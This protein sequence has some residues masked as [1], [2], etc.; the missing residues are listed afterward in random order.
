MATRVA[1]SVT[2]AV[3]PLAAMKTLRD[4]FGLPLLA[5]KQAVREHSPVPLTMPWASHPSA[6]RELALSEV[7]SHLNELLTV[8][9]RLVAAGATTQVLIG[10]ERLDRDG[11]LSA[12]A[13]VN[14]DSLARRYRGYPESDLLAIATG[15]AIVPGQPPATERELACEE[16]KTRLRD[17]DAA[18]L[19]WTADSARAPQLRR[20]LARLEMARRGVDAASL[21]I[22]A[23][24][25]QH[26]RGK[27]A[28]DTRHE[29]S[30]CYLTEEHDWKVSMD[31]RGYGHGCSKCGYFE[32]D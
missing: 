24:P 28:S 5:A 11:L 21:R 12:V 9:D 4:L 10:D 26:P 14:A 19:L 30:C 2:A 13:R 23:G 17:V 25:C 7:S 20:D 18:E 3:D 29:C 1:L 32:Q 31:A 15:H 16:L 6:T 22:T 8:I 27:F